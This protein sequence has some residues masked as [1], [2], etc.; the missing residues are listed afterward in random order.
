MYH[1]LIKSENY[2]E[3]TAI[4]TKK[5]N[6]VSRIRIKGIKT[7]QQFGFVSKGEWLLLLAMYS[8]CSLFMTFACMWIV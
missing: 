8:V 4:A 5:P 2:L 6:F 3:L 1:K 7:A